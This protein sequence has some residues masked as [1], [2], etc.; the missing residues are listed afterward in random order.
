[1]FAR[2][3]DLVKFLEKAQ[4][5]AGEDL[6][7]YIMTEDGI[8]PMPMT[9]QQM[10]EGLVSVVGPTKTFNG[11]KLYKHVVIKAPS[12]CEYDI[13]EFTKQHY[14]CMGKLQT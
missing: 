13:E 6:P 11:I 2:C 8:G 14:L 9:P 7:I 4:E 10:K 1:M 3:S 5:D 12:S